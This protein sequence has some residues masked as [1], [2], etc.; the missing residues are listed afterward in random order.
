MVKTASR[1]SG[2]PKALAQTRSAPP[3]GVRRTGNLP[4][5]VIVTDDRRLCRECLRLLLQTFDPSMDIREADSVESVK[6]LLGEPVFRHVVVYNL[7]R[8]DRAGLQAL[9]DLC[10]AVAESPVMVL[11]DSADPDMVRRVLE[12]GAQAYMPSTLPSPIMLAAL[13]LVIAGGTYAP[14]ELLLAPG[15]PRAAKAEGVAADG[16]TDALEST[17]AAGFP[18]LTRR[19]RSVLVLVARGLSNRA[20][21]AE[22]NMC[23]N[24]V[25]AHVKQIMRKLEAENRTQAALKV[26]ALTV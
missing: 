1:A 16:S 8:P 20:I 6:D 13:D 2:A 17:I 5:R 21:S 23:E 14:P 7:V 18:G 24:T 10:A 22:L 9:R 25:K 19:Q 4:I 15:A 3:G 12:M 11:C 26:A